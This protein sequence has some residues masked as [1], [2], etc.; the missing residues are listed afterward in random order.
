MENISKLTY[1]QSRAVEFFARGGF[2]NMRQA[3]MRA[4][5]TKSI[6]DQPQKVF[7]ST[8]VVNELA[9]RGWERKTA[10]SG[11]EETKVELNPK[12]PTEASPIF[13]VKDITKEQLIILKK[14]LYDI[15][16]EPNSS[17]RNETV[18][19]SSKPTSGVLEDVFSLNMT[20]TYPIEKD[21][22]KSYSSM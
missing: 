2:K 19:P 17:S 3:L 15:G 8:N 22:Y 21:I 20:E 12:P 5:Y 10:E 1:R 18:I 16:Y 14:Q 11:K 7:S 13:N 6:Y 4:G 9:G